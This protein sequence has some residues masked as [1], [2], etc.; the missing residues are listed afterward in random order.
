MSKACSGGG[1]GGGNGGSDSGGNDGS[2]SNTVEMNST[3]VANIA[4]AD[5]A[6]VPLDQVRA[7]SY[8]LNPRTL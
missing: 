5:S 6:A 7:V 8:C 1:G 4:S 2:S 3:P